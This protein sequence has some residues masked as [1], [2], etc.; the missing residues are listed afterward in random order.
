MKD[1]MQTSDLTESPNI[2]Y[3]KFFDQFEEIN[4]LPNNQWKVVHL[5]GYFAAKYQKQYNTNYTFRFNSSAPGKCYEVFQI[6]KLSNMLS[7]D[8]E[9]LKNYIDWFFEKKIVEKKKRITSMAFLTD[10]ATTN[11]YKFNVLLATTISRSSSLPQNI[12]NVVKE[13][14]QDI[15]T[16]GDLTMIKNYIDKGNNHDTY[17]NMLNALKSNNIDL[18]VLDKVI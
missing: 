10:Q 15:K 5:I 7:S 12:L 8:P 17:S 13:F 1:K 16:Y 11:E 14:D 3:Q 4:T 18:T 6:K 2:H 9:I